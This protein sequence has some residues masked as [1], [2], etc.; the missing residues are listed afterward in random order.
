MK[1]V[2]F[3]SLNFAKSSLLVPKLLFGSKHTLNFLNQSLSRFSGFF[4]NMDNRLKINHMLADS[5]GNEPGHFTN[6]TFSEKKKPTCNRSHDSREV[7]ISSSL[8]PT[9]VPLAAPHAAVALLQRRSPPLSQ[10]PPEPLQ[11]LDYKI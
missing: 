3:S 10:R 7:V 11:K 2:H 4:A 5:P 1:K 8:F 6:Q 9:P